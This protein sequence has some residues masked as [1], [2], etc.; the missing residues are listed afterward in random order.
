MTAPHV[1]PDP[2]GA[3][4]CEVHNRRECS[5]N[6]KRSKERCHDF[7]IR[8]RD[9]CKTHIGEKTEIAKA[10]GEANI[11]A[12]NA[13]KAAEAGFPPIDPGRVVL[14]QLRIAVM[15]ADLYGEMLRIQIMRADSD[16]V[17]QLSAEGLIGHT[18]AAARD[19]GAVA[20][21]E[22]VRGLARLEAEWRD[23]VVRFA[24]TAHDMGI[25]ERTVE[26]E[27][28][29]ARIVVE[30]FKAAVKAL[31]LVPADEDLALRTFLTGIGHTPDV[32]KG[33]LA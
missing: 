9:A 10:K 28:A 7:A 18:Y 2:H 21:G 32:V 33:E 15:R 26:L 13:Q 19:G 3:V 4:W 30:A 11:L 24:K 23:R 12:W 16:G 6:S 14:D 20:S 1:V 27:Q 22:Q 8:G 5:K 31:G 29:K 17:E 25:A